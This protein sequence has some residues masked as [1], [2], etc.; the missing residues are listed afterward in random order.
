MKRGLAILVL[1]LAAFFVYWFMLRK[2][3]SRGNDIKPQPIAVKKHS[4]IFNSSVDKALAAYLSIKDAFVDADT[5]KAKQNTRLFISMLDSIPVDELKKDTAVITEAARASIADIRSNAVSLLSQTDITEM[6]QDF[7]MVTEMMYP[8]FFKMIN[9]EGPKLFLQHCP[10]AFGEDKGA[11][12]ISN[13]VEIVN[14]YLG[15]NHPEFKSSM[16]HCG[17]VKDTIKAQ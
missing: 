6:R 16:L 14:P 10:M 3:G 11:D 13:N 5:A 1:L 8:G 4:E 9:Y 7:R 2:T 12:W 17:E 15:K